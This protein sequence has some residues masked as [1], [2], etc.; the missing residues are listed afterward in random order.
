MEGEADSRAR[1]DGVYMNRSWPRSARASFKF[2]EVLF[3]LN[4]C[5]A[6][7]QEQCY[8]EAWHLH[9]QVLS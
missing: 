4:F 2:H 7:C 9:S 3:K 8:R 6:V 1:Y 5:S